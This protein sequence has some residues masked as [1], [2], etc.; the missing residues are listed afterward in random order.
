MDKIEKILTDVKEKNLSIDDAKQQLIH[1]ILQ[2]PSCSIKG[3]EMKYLQH[4]DAWYCIDCRDFEGYSKR[5][6]E[7]YKLGKN[8]D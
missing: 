1:H 8:D 3:H 4:Q 5:F 6:F 7:G 2:K